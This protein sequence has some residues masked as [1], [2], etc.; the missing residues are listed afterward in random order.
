[1]GKLMSYST[2]SQ[3]LER[4]PL[5]L[6]FLNLIDP[7]SRN[8][9]I[10]TADSRLFLDWIETINIV[11]SYVVSGLRARA[12]PNELDALTL[13]AVELGAWFRE[14]LEDFRGKQLPPIDAERLAP[15]NR[16]LERDAQIIQIDVRDGIENRI[17]GSGLKSST[18]RIWHS[19]DMLL[20]PIADDIARLLC[21]QDFRTIS[22]CEA[23]GCRAY[24]LN[25]I[26]D[27]EQNSCLCDA[28]AITCHSRESMG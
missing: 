23:T 17:A 13:E 20:L 1:M 11:P 15:L 18:R 8:R 10:P 16:L 28:H 7:F 2:S 5:C 27:A 19:P 14:F 22:K 12:D 3:R 9:R 24:F 26:G 4:H 6:H 25:T 21:K